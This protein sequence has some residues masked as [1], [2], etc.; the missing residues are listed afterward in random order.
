MSRFCGIARSGEATDRLLD[1][2]VRHVTLRKTWD[3][4]RCDASPVALAWA[5]RQ[6]GGCRQSHGVCVVLDGRI[7]NREEL[8]GADDDASLILR[9]YA[10]LG[11]EEML[12]RLNGDFAFALHDEN[13]GETW[14]A[15]DRFGVRPLYYVEAPG[16]AFASRA[17]ALLLLPGVSRAVDKEYVALVAACHYRTFDNRSDASPYRDVH[18]LPAAH[19]LRFDGEDLQVRRYWDMRPGEDL[20]G[21]EDELAWQYREL[22]LDAVRI[23]VASVKRPA[24]TLSGGMDS[25]SVL[26]SAV[27]VTAKKQ[28][29]YSTVYDDV[30]YDESEDIQTVLDD[31]V[32]TWHPVLVEAPDVLALVQEMVAMHEEPVATAT[33]LSHYLLCRQVHDDGFEALFGGLGGD[34]LNAGE[35]EYFPFHFA[36]LLRSGDTAAFQHEVE[37]WSSH[38]DHPVYQ[39]NE[40]RAKELVARLTDPDR[41]GVCLP[42]RERLLRYQKALDPGFF[43]LRRYQPTMEHPFPSYLKN[44]TYQDMTRET[45]PCCLRAEDRHGAAFDVHN[46]DPFFDHRLAEFMFRVPGHMKIRDGITKRLLREAMQGVLPDETR[47]RIKKTGWNAPAHIWFT[48]PGADAV[49]ALVRSKRFRSRGIYDVEEV[50]RIMDEH[51]HIVKSGA[52]AENHMMFLW[53]LVNLEMWLRWNEEQ[54]IPV[55]ESAR[56]A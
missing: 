6:G 50:E 26:A 39:K 28:H 27:R 13:T 9:L 11:M 4:E 17:G 12:S 40:G 1:Q 41:P 47:T 22:L 19:Y 37:R 21:S 23:R 56:A 54:E 14:L 33:W 36:D 25:S 35:Y 20:A 49:R 30:T 8:G 48:G 15:R 42:D 52:V 32:E 5:G 29:A 10:E 43:D 46:V 2:M 55:T 34:E 38:H 53:Q 44:R 3:Q 24:F 45:A 7:Y 51:E 31:L 16:F 18:L